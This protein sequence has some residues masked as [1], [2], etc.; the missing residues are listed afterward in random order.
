MSRIFITSSLVASLLVLV[1]STACSSDPPPGTNPP[2]DGSAVATDN[3][4]RGKG[5]ADASGGDVGSDGEP[6]DAKGQTAD[7]DDVSQKV[8][9][10][11]VGDPAA[12]FAESMII[13]MP[14]GMSDEALM[15]RTP[16]MM[17]LSREIESVG[18]GADGAGGMITWASFGYFEEDA[19]KTLEAFR[20]ETM[21]QLYARKD[22][23]K[24][25]FK[26]SDQKTKGR[27]LDVVVDVP[28]DDAQ[29]RAARRAWFVIKAKYGRMYW[30]LYETD[31][32]AWNALKNSF[33]ESTKKLGLLDPEA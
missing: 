31:P 19:N 13:R 30:V 20:D 2:E 33:V 16:W 25:A 22:G 14:K 24:V 12:L 26:Y 4:G 23:A 17:T 11:D 27:R 29:Q 3:G 7:A 18:C 1:L 10:A 9:D 5:S 21:G 28:A 6:A 8:C 32:R 15:E